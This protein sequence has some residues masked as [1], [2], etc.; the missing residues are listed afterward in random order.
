[1]QEQVEKVPD[2]TPPKSN[3]GWFQRGD[4]RINREGRPR[5]SKA[6]SD[7]GSAPADRASC[8]DRLMTLFVPGPDLAHRL[9]YG[10][11][12][13]IVN[14]PGDCEIVA[15]RHDEARDGVVLVIRSQAFP[16]IAQGAVIPAFAPTFKGLKWRA[17]NSR[18]LDVYPGAYTGVPR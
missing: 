14:L 3:R 10:S 11:G 17:S 8:A 4:R 9:S 7:D 1:M 5:G 15:Y 18:W 13:W 6:G 12:P 2:G 16:R